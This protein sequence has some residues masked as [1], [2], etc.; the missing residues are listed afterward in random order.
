MA[1]GY[2]VKLLR[3]QSGERFPIL[4]G[5]GGQPLFD[6]TVYALTELRGRNQATNTIS[7]ALRAIQVFVIFLDLRKID[8]SARLADGHLLSLSE[9]EDLARLCRLP[10]DNFEGVCDDAGGDRSRHSFS[11]ENIRMRP[12]ATAQVEVSCVVAATRMRSIRNYLEWLSSNHLSRNILGKKTA[13]A[14]RD[15]REHAMRAFAAR[16]PKGRFSGTTDSREGL[17]PE[18]SLELLRVVS[19]DCSDN[20]WT[21][22]YTRNRNALIVYWLFYLGIRRGELLGIRVQ[23]I[24]LRKGTVTIHRRADDVKDPRRNQPQTKTRARELPLGEALQAQ[25]YDYIMN[26]RRTLEGARRHDF[27][28]CA[29][30]SGQPMSLPALNKVF[31]ILRLKCGNLPDTLS[32]HVLRHTWNDRFSEEMDRRSVPEEDEKKRRAYLMGWSEFSGTAATYTRRH[33]RK[34]AR[35]AS[36]GIQGQVIKKRLSDD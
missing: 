18:A 25:V 22:S 16:I 2:K 21:T 10:M 11:S 17:S 30:G 5:P 8:L 7:N 20:P 34:K 19:P 26:H 1:A 14:L 33:I 24:D 28:L 31:K 3:W 32:P 9:I 23:D 6:S 15:A 12:Q 35:E 4:L 36:L 27:L 13:S 29:D